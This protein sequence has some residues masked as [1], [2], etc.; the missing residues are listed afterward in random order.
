MSE[1][2][3]I[4][5]SHLYSIFSI[6]W[7]K[8]QLFGITPAIQLQGVP[9]PA[10]CHIVAF[11]P[12]APIALLPR[13]VHVS[14]RSLVLVILFQHGVDFFADDD[15][16]WPDFAAIILIRAVT[17]ALRGEFWVRFGACL[18]RYR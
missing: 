13:A 8:R 9:P 6:A 1:E 10:G 2:Q 11:R 14:A 4:P 5:V 17:R 7:G 18:A 16:A 3:E 12:L 15:L